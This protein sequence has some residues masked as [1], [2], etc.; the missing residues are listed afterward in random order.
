[1]PSL[2][3]R[4]GPRVLVDAVAVVLDQ[5]LGSR[6]EEAGGAASRVADDVLRRGCGHVHHQLDDVARRAELSVLPGSRDLAEHVLV[7]IALGVAVGHVDVVELIDHVGQHPSR[8]HHEEGVLH[9][10]GVG[11]AFVRLPRPAHRLDEGEHPVAYRLEH[12]LRRK[13]LETRPAQSV[14][15]GGEHR[16][17]DRLPGAGGLVL[18][19]RVQL[20]QPLDEQQVGELLDDRERVRDAAGPQG[21]PDSVDLGLQLTG[22]HDS[23]PSVSTRMLHKSLVR[24]LSRPLDGGFFG[25]FGMCAS[26]SRRVKMT[27]MPDRRHS[28]CRTHRE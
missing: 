19:A 9:V 3:R 12:L 1:M 22:D 7:E 15:V 24:V 8:G 18:L 16:L 20:V 17:L 10:M 4:A 11:G 6:D 13:L 14:L 27:R 28:R 5:M 2:N 25:P 26:S 21:V 23:I